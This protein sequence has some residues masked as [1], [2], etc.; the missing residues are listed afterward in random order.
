[1][2]QPT[3][4]GGS[5]RICCNRCLDGSR[6]VS[7]NWPCYHSIPT[8]MWYIYI[9]EKGRCER[10]SFF[11]WFFERKQTCALDYSWIRDS[12]FFTSM[13]D[14][15]AFLY[16]S[17]FVPSLVKLQLIWLNT[18][19]QISMKLY[20]RSASGFS[21]LQVSFATTTISIRQRDINN[22][23]FLALSFSWCWEKCDDKEA[24]KGGLLGPP[25]GPR[26]FF[27]KMYGVYMIL[28]LETSLMLRKM[29]YVYNFI[30]TNLPI[31]FP[32]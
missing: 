9:N 4:R 23:I 5:D 26:R 27:W 16:L 24:F 3:F 22:N 19:R 12:S 14:S 25:L 32:T 30:H 1:M 21:N 17:H 28:P 20:Y 10:I 2:D 7:A 29:I 31:L 15:V 11:S 8:R 6:G 13:H 18:C